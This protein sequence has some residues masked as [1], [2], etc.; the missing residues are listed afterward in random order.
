MR[1]LELEG[2]ISAQ[3]DTAL[4]LI[5]HALTVPLFSKKWITNSGNRKGSW[6]DQNQA[7]SEVGKWMEILT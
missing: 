6:M 4:G 3:D 1:H 5:S 7:T 2:V